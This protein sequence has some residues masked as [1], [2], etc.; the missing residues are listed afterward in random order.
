VTDGGDFGD[1]LV[2]E[3]AHGGSAAMLV[4]AHA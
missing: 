1:T 3:T 2:T 4:Q